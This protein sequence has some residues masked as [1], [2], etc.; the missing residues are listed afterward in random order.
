M[1]GIFGSFDYN[2][3][4][5]L[6]AENGDRGNF[7]SGSMYYSKKTGIYLRRDKHTTLLT[8][9]RAF[10]ERDSYDW[11][12]GHRQAPTTTQRAFKAATT[13]PFDYKHWI[14]AHNGIIENYSSLLRDHPSHQTN[15]VDSSII[16]VLLDDLYVGSDELAI[17]E[18]CN[19]L[20]GTFGCW[21]FS[22]HTR[23]TYIVRSGSTVFADKLTGSFS[24][25]KHASHAPSALDEGTIY[26]VT[27]EGLVSVGE[28]KSNSPFLIL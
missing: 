3:Y 15:P 18:T 21:I 4:E 7:A 9:E 1:C 5:K 2:V 13:H 11:F 20:Q 24:S 10:L 6:Y 28:F 16:P 27:A 14:V 26:L 25:V 19:R 8:G 17:S 12:A 22:K 23:K